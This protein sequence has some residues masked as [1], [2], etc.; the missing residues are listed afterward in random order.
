M[1][2]SL[3]VKN[4]GATMSNR[5]GTGRRWVMYLMVAVAAT[6]FA[7][8]AAVTGVV[9]EPAAEPTVATPAPTAAAPIATPDPKPAPVATPAVAATPAPAPS[10]TPAAPREPTPPP[11]VA[12]TPVAAATPKPTP[13]P[14]APTPVAT[15]VATPEPTPA[16]TPVATPEPT[17]AATPVATPEPTPAATPQPTPAATP[18][19]PAATPTPPA[20]M[21]APVAAATPEPT[22]APTPA[23]A[24]TPTPC[25]DLED[26]CTPW[27]SVFITREGNAAGYIEFWN[28]GPRTVCSFATTGFGALGDE[29]HAAA[30]AATQAW[31]EAV[32]GEPALFAYQP[33]C[34]EG[35]A[36]AWPEHTR[37]CDWAYGDA[38]QDT[39]YIPVIWVTAA[40]AVATHGTAVACA[41]VGGAHNGDP[42]FTPR[43][44]GWQAAVIV[45][46]GADV[47]GGYDRWIAHE[48]GHILYL[49]HTCNERSIML[50]R[51][52]TPYVP[53]GIIPADYLQIRA[54]LGR[55]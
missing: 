13:A 30:R 53:S 25:A 28:G 54:A 27:D 43:R 37:T 3:T 16:A 45:G 36:A 1:R 22:P 40:A 29:H 2:R 51:C 10:A 11:A 46:S 38:R 39:E 7:A 49:G 50:G 17:P 47:D 5:E 19:P 44:P 41:V 23:P 26:G 24:P 48:L 6:A 52:S 14:V 18:T 20:P 42:A 31:N 35:F 12:A 15:P 9:T 8:W 4:Q 32:G 33:D 34:P 21:V 55:N